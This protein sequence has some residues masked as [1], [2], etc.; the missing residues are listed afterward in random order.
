MTEK[1]LSLREQ[2]KEWDKFMDAFGSLLPGGIGIYE[3]SDAVYPI[4][5]SPGVIR[6]SSGFDEESY[7]NPQEYVA[8]N[9]PESE[10]KKLEE[11]MDA[12]I[13]FHTLLDCTLRYR[14]T[15]KRLGW[16]WIRGRMA[17]ETGR[18]KIFLAL[19]LD[20]TKQKEIETELS[21]Q[22]QR[23]RILE[24]TSDEILFELRLEDDE[25]T[26]SYKEMDGELIRKRVPHYSHVLEHDPFVHPD[27]IELFRQHLQ[28]AMSREINGQIEYL[29]NISGHGYEWHHMYYSSLTDENGK[30]N[31]IIG[32][33]KNVHDEVLSRQKKE[34]EA[35]FGM[36]QV[37]SIEQSIWDK[38][39]NA[40]FDDKHSLAII[41]IDHYK[42]IIEQNGVAWGDTAVRKVAELLKNIVGDDTV[43][44]RMHDGDI[45]VYLKN[46]DDGEMDRMM[47][48][49]G[50]EVLMP[51]NQVAGIT[52]SCTIGAAIM[53]GIT[54]YMTFY[55]EAEEA[56]HIAKITKGEHYIRV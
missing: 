29:T 18:R 3:C 40:E 51:A 52:V 16:V 39:D 6:L 7:R 30:V 4:Y 19:I 35:E 36:N 49:I 2:I 15:P 38:L 10:Q 24:E 33:I 47:E 23:Y 17:Q 12:A 41:S 32:R 55:Q 8:L 48:E 27:N 20:V 1:D 13:E 54:D 11:A 22:N 46:I 28:V 9:L 21:V 26:Y 37:S 45:L 25:M 5:L 44:G 56:L 50:K 53:Y 43:M 34:Q 14:R 31:R 42:Q